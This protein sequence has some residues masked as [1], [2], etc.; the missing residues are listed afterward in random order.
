MSCE[1][2]LSKLDTQGI[3][4]HNNTTNE[5]DYQLFNSEGLVWSEYPPYEYIHFQL[6]LEVFLTALF[7][8]NIDS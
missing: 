8:T 7:N 2:R 5:F 6:V 1:A 4:F 3:N